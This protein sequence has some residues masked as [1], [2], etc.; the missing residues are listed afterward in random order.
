[1]YTIC[2]LLTARR[3]VE[4]RE[5]VN[6]SVSKVTLKIKEIIE[7]SGWTYIIRPRLESFVIAIIS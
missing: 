7:A 1:M 4:S 6:F 3:E 5:N 2:K